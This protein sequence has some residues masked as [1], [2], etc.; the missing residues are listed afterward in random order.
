MS[1]VRSFVQVYEPRHHTGWYTLWKNSDHQKALKNV[2]NRSRKHPN[3]LFRVTRTE[4]YA[5]SFDC[6]DWRVV[7][8]RGQ[9]NPLS[10]HTGEYYIA[11]KEMPF[12]QP[13]AMTPDGK[14]TVN[15]DEWRDY[16]R[17]LF[18][19][20]VENIGQPML[21][22]TVERFVHRDTVKHSIKPS[23]WEAW[24]SFSGCYSNK[25]SFGD[26]F[27][28]HSKYGGSVAARVTY[29]DVATEGAEYEYWYDG[30]Q[31]N[32][33]YMV[34]KNDQDRVRE[35]R[36]KL[37]RSVPEEITNALK[38]MFAERSIDTTTVFFAELVRHFN[39][40]IAPSMVAADGSSYKAMQR[41]VSLL[42]KISEAL[43][44]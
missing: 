41:V 34:E 28:N 26:A 13:H 18:Q 33:M 15:S 36:W 27:K 20:A 42:D 2:Q 35:N 1:T 44:S 14:L 37:E 43:E 4:G 39:G 31:I 29:T 7:I 5:G 21:H 11:G 6:E 10:I 24:D 17:S 23:V 8:Y 12:V 38:G 40:V 3:Y 32:D 25:L 30:E 9:G 19:V 16:M 22:I